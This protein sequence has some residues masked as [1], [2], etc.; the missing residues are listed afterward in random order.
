[1][2]K[3]I[4]LLI[5]FLWF[6][7]LREFW[8]LSYM[9]LMSLVYV[10]IFEVPCFEKF[11]YFFSEWGVDFMGFSLVVLSVWISILMISSSWMIKKIEYFSEYFLWLVLLLLLILVLC[12]FSINML[13]FYLFFEISLIPTLLIIMGWGFQLE[14]LQ[15]GVYFMF[16]TLTAS[17]PLLL[18]L[19]S[20]FLNIGTLK[21]LLLIKS[22]LI[23]VTGLLSMIFL[24]SLILAFLVKLPVFFVHLWLPKAHVEAPVAGSMIL[25]GVLLKLGGFGLSRVLPMVLKISSGING[26][27]IGLGLMS[28]IY[29]GFMC[30]RL[31]DLKALVAYSSVSH[32]G[33]VLAGLLTMYVWGVTGGLIMMVS[34]GLSSSGL[35]CAVNMFYERLSSRSMYFN[36]GLLLIYPSLSFLFFMLCAANISAP[37]TI[38]LMGEIFLMASVM[39]FSKIMM[40][41]FPL[42]SFLGAVFTLFMYSYSQHGKNYF[43]GV[44]FLSVNLNEI[45]NLILHIVPLN[46]MILKAEYFFF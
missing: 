14:R 15:A 18:N 38:N 7:K 19:I 44:N 33:L 23:E 12:F 13:Y 37:P 30:C 29:V 36:K 40:V 9:M 41:I 8:W 1:M 46:L 21:Y 2:M 22:S 10:L 17:L 27:L 25:A 6:K 16:Y 20:L 31:N 24:M 42:G 34:H 4:F 26:Y 5:S 3:F 35:F 11:H 39:G 43:L 45:H 32:M 28:M